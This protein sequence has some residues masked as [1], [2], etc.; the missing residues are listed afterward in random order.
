MADQAQPMRRRGCRL[1]LDFATAKKRREIG[2]LLEAYRGAVNF[3][4]RSLWQVPGGLDNE[5]RA[6][7]P[8]ERTR[9][10]AM[11]KDQALRQALSIVSSARRSANPLGAEEPPPRFSGMAVLCQGVT[12]EPGRGSFDLVVRISTL[13]AGERITIPTRKTR[14]LDKWLAMPGAGLIQGCALSEQAIVVW[15][16]FPRPGASPAITQAVRISST[17]ERS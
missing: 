7:L 8:T 14:V 13:R 1:S 11:H 10:Q 2:R 5:T 9:L 16:E 17:L 12:I 15:V 4:V 3:Y 6:R